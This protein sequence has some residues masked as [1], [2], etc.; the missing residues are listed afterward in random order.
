MSGQ[1]W[2][3]IL[4]VVGAIHEIAGVAVIGI[5]IRRTRVAVEKLGED[6]QRAA[7]NPT[8]SVFP[9]GDLIIGMVTL[10]VDIT[11]RSRGLRMAGVVFL[12]P[13]ISLTLWANLRTLQTESSA[14]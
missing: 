8:N 14:D 2:V 5:D 3:A 11:S 1:A 4:I 12:L 10:M 9:I 6:S 7:Q 13:G